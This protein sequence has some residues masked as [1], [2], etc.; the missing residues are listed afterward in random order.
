[1]INSQV[2]ES[3]PLN[4]ILTISVAHNDALPEEIKTK[5]VSIQSDHIDGTM[6][7]PKRTKL[8]N[9]LKADTTTNSPLERGGN[10]VDGVLNSLSF[11]EASNDS[12]SFGEGRGEG[13]YQ[14]FHGICLTDTFQLGE[15]KEESQSDIE[16]EIFSKNNQR[17]IKQKNKPIKVIMG[18]PPYR[19]KQKTTNEDNAQKKNISNYQIE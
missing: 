19:V 7:A 11:R 5:M 10:E 6:S 3:D 9:W 4:K 17:I 8:M 14:P 12:L 16:N 2:V 15:T 13:I 18:N 1:M